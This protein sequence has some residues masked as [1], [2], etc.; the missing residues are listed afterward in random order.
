MFEGLGFTSWG[1]GQAATGAMGIMTR[2][3]S[4]LWGLHRLHSGFGHGFYKGV[5]ERLFGSGLFRF[6]F[7]R[8]SMRMWMYRV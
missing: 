5:R 4:V 2:F 7:R 1:F 8:D 6:L 3:L